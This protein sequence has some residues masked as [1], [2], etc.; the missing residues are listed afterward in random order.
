[1]TNKPS[2]APDVSCTPLLNQMQ[3]TAQF[4]RAA[5]IPVATASGGTAVHGPAVQNKAA[6]RCAATDRG[7]HWPSVTDA[8]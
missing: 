6:A 1:M 4:D 2:S 7:L 5:R 3:P 8:T